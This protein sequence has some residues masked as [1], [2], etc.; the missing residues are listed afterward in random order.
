M[1]VKAAGLLGQSQ[2][3]RA[4]KVQHQPESVQRRDRV[5]R[6]AQPQSVD[7]GCDLRG[8]GGSFVR[9]DLSS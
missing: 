3:G 8:L 4:K 1:T 5:W 2:Q 6:K 7:Q 9:G